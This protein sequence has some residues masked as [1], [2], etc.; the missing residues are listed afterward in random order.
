MR[1]IKF[2]GK[3]QGYNTWV[4]GSLVQDKEGNCIIISTPECAI[5]PMQ[6][7]LVH[8]DTVG[9]FTGLLDCNGKEIYEGD[10][11][12]STDFRHQIVYDNDRAAF[13]AKGIGNWAYCPIGKDWITTFKKKVIGNIHNNPGLLSKSK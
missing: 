11:I 2:R 10:V 7:T 13:I 12:E 8:S 6:R 9:Q 1:T 3:V 4:Y 5:E